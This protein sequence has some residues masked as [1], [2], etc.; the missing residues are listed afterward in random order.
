MNRPAS[1]AGRVALAL[2]AL[3]ILAS[4]RPQADDQAINQ[5]TH[6]S[7]SGIYPHLAYSNTEGECGTGA[8]VPWAGR[9]WVISYGPHLP[10]GSSD[11]LYEIDDALH[12]VTRPESVGGTPAGRMIHRESNQLFIGPYAIDA[13]RNV[14]VIQPKVMPGRLTGIARHLTDPAHKLY[15]GTMEEGFYEVDV[16]S[17]AVKTL[18]PDANTLPG[19]HA[20]PLLPGYHGK[21]L[22]SGQGRLIYANNGELS[23][24][25]MKRPDIASGCLAE[26]DGATWT[27]VRRNQFTDV[28][29]PGGIEGNAQPETDP[30]W[31]IGWD[32][33]SLILMCRDRGSWHAYRLPKASHSYDGSHGWNTEWPR[34][35]DIGEDDLLMTMHGAFWRFPRSFCSTNSKGLAQRSTYLKVIGDFALWNDRVVFGCDDAAKSSFLTKRAARGPILT[36]GRSQSN[37]WF[38][39]PAKLDNLGPPI[40]RGAVWLDDAIEAGAP[41]EPYL[42]DGFER[43]AVHL[44]HTND[45]PVT[46]TFETD[47]NGDGTWGPLQTVIVPANGST[48]VE[49]APT[50]R[51]AWVRVRADRACAKA[52][53][54]FTGSNPDRRD[55]TADPIFNGLATIDAKDWDGGLLR[56]RGDADLTLAVEPVAAR[57]ETSEP[58]WHYTMD[59]ALKF[60]TVPAP[61]AKDALA[62]TCAVPKGVVT[63]EKRSVL[64]VDDAGQRWRLP[65]GGPAFDTPG[66]IDLRVCRELCT[67]RDLLNVHG[68]VYEHPADNAGGTS[69]LRPIAS[70][71]LK[72]ADFTSW[73]G[74]LV[75]TGVEAGASTSTN[76]RIVRSDDGRA[77]VWLGAIDDLWRLGKPVGTGGPWLDSPVQPGVPSDPYLMTGYDHKT[78]ELAQK[79]DAPV[80]V[81]V[82]LDITGAGGWVTYQVIEVQPGAPT[83]VKL[84]DALS[85]YWVRFVSDTAC[86]AT[87]ILTYD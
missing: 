27:V 45:T 83:V 80:H 26:W 6:V 8:V 4:S 40:G 7:V 29:G 71:R 41:S 37:L 30:I 1:H 82:E 19:G 72:I 25:A 31:S 74:L 75:M 35:R 79:S 67:E 50:A 22:Y 48:W 20:G 57:G 34:I 68:T 85:A 13:S 43:R 9:L 36:A 69:K 12:R 56:A 58:S 33:R 23:A 32:H 5:S 2:A 81:R 77:A 49:F 64:Y 52:T 63:I 28:S 18:F 21:G 3:A 55:T 70:H 86:K 24:D 54:M 46:F 11:K 73:R 53:A 44:A 65:K 51:G 87:A 39:E 60:Q 38:V 84:P 76:P 16:A 59:S 61:A 47:A 66:P 78:L 10:R 14:R 15:Y 62:T 17:L 42:F